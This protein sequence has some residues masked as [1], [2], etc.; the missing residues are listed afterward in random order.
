ML[1]VDI[2]F[3]DMMLGNLV[4]TT[5]GEP[6][7]TFCTSCHKSSLYIDASKPEQAGSG[8]PE[9]A[10]G[11]GNHGMPTNE[12]SCMGCHAGPYDQGGS[13]VPSG[14]G[15][16]PG[17]IH[18]ASYTWTESITSGSPTDSFI[19]GGYINGFYYDT[20]AGSGECGG[21]T[22]SHANGQS[23]SRP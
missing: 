2:D 20:V 3:D 16:A 11:K 13:A 15:A 4:T 1:T 17:I 5:M 8:F 23:Y 12:L 6:I 21:G 10:G 9:H 19:L 7:L 18:G 22:C 14:N